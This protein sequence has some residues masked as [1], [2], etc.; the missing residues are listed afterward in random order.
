VV[1]SAGADKKIRIWR[2]VKKLHNFRDIG[3]LRPLLEVLKFL[4]PRKAIRVQESTTSFASLL[5]TMKCSPKCL[6]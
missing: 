1:V 5:F 3:N 6:F 2:P 4:T